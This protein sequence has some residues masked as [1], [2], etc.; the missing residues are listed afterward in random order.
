MLVS[1]FPAVYPEH[2]Y[3]VRDPRRLLISAFRV[4]VLGIGIF[5]LW[6]WGSSSGPG[7]AANAA[8]AQGPSVW[9][10]L[11]TVAMILELLYLRA[12]W[13]G[14]VID[15]STAEMVYPGG[16]VSAN[17]FSDYLRPRYLLQRF[18]RFRVAL[19]DIRSIRGSNRKVMSYSKVFMGASPRKRN[20]TIFGLSFVGP[21][22][23]ATIWFHDEGKRDELRAAIQQSNRMGRPVTIT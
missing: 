1:K 10:I 5:G 12:N 15:F 3:R 18:L 9:A 22:G 7:T 2:R 23:A 4:T 6:V 17:D 20:K 21:C 19:R 14:A 16:G 13:F 11:G 8:L